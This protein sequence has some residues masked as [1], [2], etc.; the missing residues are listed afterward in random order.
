MDEQ[1]NLVPTGSSYYF[2]PWR[3]D[4]AVTGADGA[5]YQFIYGHLDG[6]IAV[7]VGQTVTPDTI[8]GGVGNKF[9][10]P[11]Q[12]NIHVHI[13]ITDWTYT[14]NPLPFF[15]YGLRSSLIDLAVSLL[16][17]NLNPKGVT[18]N[19]GGLTTQPPRICRLEGD[20]PYTTCP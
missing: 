19:S 18:F 12:G 16:D 13:E 5:W 9:G 8:I 15:S 14:Y 20:I 1:G 7:S 3:V 11:K 10:D 2:G 17:L 6:N 4:I